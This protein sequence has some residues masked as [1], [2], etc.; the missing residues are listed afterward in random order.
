MCDTWSHA[1]SRHM[2]YANLLSRLGND[3]FGWGRGWAP[4]EGVKC[5]EDRFCIYHFTQQH[6]RLRMEDWSVRRV[7]WD[8]GGP[9]GGLEGCGEGGGR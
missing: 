1:S 5:L 7:R 9:E 8:V 6:S 4:R 3:G 2:G